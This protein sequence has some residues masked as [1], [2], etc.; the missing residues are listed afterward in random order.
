MGRIRHEVFHSFKPIK[1]TRCA[2]CATRNILLN[3]YIAD[4]GWSAIVIVKARS[5]SSIG[6]RSGVIRLE[7]GWRGGHEREVKFHIRCTV[8]EGQCLLEE[9]DPLEIKSKIAGLRTGF[10][11]LGSLTTGGVLE[12]ELGNDQVLVLVAA[13]Q[14]I[15]CEC[16]SSELTGNLACADWT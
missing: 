3:H 14:H 16:Q 13:C 8:K 11:V 7:Q 2:P 15:A 10:N 5:G 1:Q 9:C 4:S 6:Y 12:S